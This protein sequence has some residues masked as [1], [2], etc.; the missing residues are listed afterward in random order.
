MPFVIVSL[1]FGGAHL[2]AGFATLAAIVQI[3]LLSAYLT[4]LRAVSG[5]VRPSLVAHMVWNMA[6]AVALI[7]ANS[8][9]GLKI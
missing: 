1:L 9:P 5:S 3:V 6:G 2:L 7:L 8:I 4:A